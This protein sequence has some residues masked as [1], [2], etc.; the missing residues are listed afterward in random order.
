MQ[1]D[2]I[3]NL[4]AVPL[5]RKLGLGGPP[6]QPGYKVTFTTSNLV[7]AGTSAQVFF[8]LIG[9]YGSS[10]AVWCRRGSG[11]HLGVWCRRGSGALRGL[12]QEG[13]RGTYE[14]AGWCGGRQPG[15]PGSFKPSGEG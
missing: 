6:G 4:A 12:V 1:T 11:A 9:T 2:P 10:G 13:V 5:L 14:S 3:S 8:E 15:G 7:C